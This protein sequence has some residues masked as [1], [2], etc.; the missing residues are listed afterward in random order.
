MVGRATTLAVLPARARI[1]ACSAMAVVRMLVRVVC[2]VD[3]LMWL[4]LGPLLLGDPFVLGLLLS[5][6]DSLM[7]RPSP[8]DRGRPL[9][10]C[11]DDWR[12]DARR[13][14]PTTG[15]SCSDEVVLRKSEYASPLGELPPLLLLMKSYLSP[16][17]SADSWGGWYAISGVG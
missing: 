13:T 1:C 8:D 15:V 9:W 4:S 3:E 5:T 11:E 17:P 16:R 6:L 12:P 7:P 14:Y 10:L 2:P